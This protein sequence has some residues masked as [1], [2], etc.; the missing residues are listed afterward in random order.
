M[1]K[2]VGRITASEQAM[3]NSVG[4]KLMKGRN[5][6]W[7][8][9]H[10]GYRRPRPILY[11][12][13]AEVGEFRT[14]KSTK[15]VCS[16]VIND[17]VR[18]ITFQKAYWSKRYERWSFS[19]GNSLSIPINLEYNFEGIDIINPLE[20]FTLLLAKAVK[21]GNELP[22]DNPENYVYKMT[23]DERMEAREQWIDR[24]ERAK[25]KMRAKNEKILNNRAEQLKKEEAIRAKEEE[26]MAQRLSE[27]RIVDQIDVGFVKSLIQEIGKET[28]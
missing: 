7:Y 16:I 2:D 5:E 26:R 12:N 14:G 21:V 13:T 18:L 11:T 10:R 22:L 8:V 20:A 6:P 15:M 24:A 3:L 19:K 27:R 17:G 25:D 1:A 9:S 28:K 23:K 4:P